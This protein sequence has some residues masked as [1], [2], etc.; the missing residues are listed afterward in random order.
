MPK[1]KKLE[2][3]EVIPNMDFFSLLHD[4]LEDDAWYCN[5]LHF[6]IQVPNNTLI[7]L[8]FSVS[9]PPQFHV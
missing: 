7:F 4:K 2:G 9:E 1:L 8:G 6:L 5:L 3:K